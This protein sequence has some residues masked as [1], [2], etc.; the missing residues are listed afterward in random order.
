MIKLY[1][2]EDHRYGVEY[3]NG[4]LVNT[5]RPLFPKESY[6][7]KAYGNEGGKNPALNMSATGLLNSAL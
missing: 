1:E 6:L 7:V 4:L 3:H 5:E 2:Q